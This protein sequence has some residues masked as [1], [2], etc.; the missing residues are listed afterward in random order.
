MSSIIWQLVQMSII[1]FRRDKSKKNIVWRSIETMQMMN[2]ISKGLRQ[3]FMNRFFI[4]LFS[5]SS[6]L[7]FSPSFT[8]F[9]YLLSIKDP[10][11]P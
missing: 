1:K 9:I 4:A 7:P 10:V 5:T 3:I 2:T 6:E 11:E 8:A